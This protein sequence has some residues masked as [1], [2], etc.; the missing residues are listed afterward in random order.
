[1]YRQPQAP[2]VAISLQHR[3]AW[4]QL[5]LRAMGQL[6]HDSVVPPQHCQRHLGLRHVGVL[7]V[8]PSANRRPQHAQLRQVLTRF[9][10]VPPGEFVV[11]V[12]REGHDIGG[13]EENLFHKLVRILH[14]PIRA[15][16]GEILGAQHLQLRV[17]P[18]R[19]NCVHQC[20]VT[21]RRVRSITCVEDAQV[22][23]AS[24]FPLV[25]C[26]GLVVARAGESN[27]RRCW[28]RRVSHYRPARDVLLRRS[29][30]RALRRN[31][32][33]QLLMHLPVCALLPVKLV[34]FFSSFSI[35]DL[36]YLAVR[37]SLV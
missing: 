36:L 9:Q 4:H 21:R 18:L 13:Q 33:P 20:H 37:L 7:V 1:M 16:L 32:I 14:Q 35:E 28:C 27:Q 25:S 30:G 2:V 10:G 31:L 5:E 24:G 29:D 17:G 11:V 6:L 34:K 3:C 23:T 12:L 22:G 26:F 15:I 8:P 19:P